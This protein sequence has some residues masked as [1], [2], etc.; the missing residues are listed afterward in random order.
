MLKNYFKIA[1]RNLW[2]HKWFSLINIVGL[3]IGFTVVFFIV[4][5]VL[6]ELS[7]DNFHDKG[8]RIYRVVTDIKT[9]SETIFWPVATWA[10]APHLKSDFDEIKN[11]VRIKNRPFLVRNNHVNFE[12]NTLIA[13]ASFF[14]I[15]D[16]KLLTGN[17]ETALK[18]PFSVV[19]TKKCA[20]KYFE[21]RN[22]L[23]RTL[24]ITSDGKEYLAQITGIIAEFPENSHIKSDFILSMSSITQVIA[25]EDD[26]DNK[27]SNYS[28]FTYILLNK[29]VNHKV[30]ESKFPEF[31]RKNNGEEMDELKMYPTLFLEPF[32]KVYLHSTR[33]GM[34]EGN[35][36]NVYTFL[37][38]AVLILLIAC[39]NFSPY[40]K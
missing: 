19:L 33:G 8:D 15:F 6:F 29:N 36:T 20:Q 27:W 23:G 30:L 38:I 25:K 2:N 7:Y 12:E 4:Q 10:I 13:G 26:L 34:Q 24:T 17:P 40:A 9:P 35:I 11:T 16:F 32:T 5:Y 18:D 39:I 21:N 22:P 28:S 14:N 1:W 37:I 31:L 3:T